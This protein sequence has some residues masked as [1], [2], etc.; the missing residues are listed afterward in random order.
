MKYYLY[1]LQ[2]M[3]HCSQ[4]QNQLMT[5]YSLLKERLCQYQLVTV[6]CVNN[7]AVCLSVCAFSALTLWQEGHLACKKKSGGVLVWLSVWSKVQTTLWS[8]YILHDQHAIFYF[9][10]S[11]SK[12]I[13]MFPLGNNFILFCGC[14]LVVEALGNYPVCPPLNP[15]LDTTHR[16]VPRR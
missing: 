8:T 7:S 4:Y 15:A 12:S 3:Q 2:I 16:A 9:R 10:L 6:I 1:T 11:V 14:P 5:N 13:F